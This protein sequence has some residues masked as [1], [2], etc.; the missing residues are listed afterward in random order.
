MKRDVERLR[1]R[2]I[3]MAEKVGA[4]RDA[5]RQIIEDAESLVE[6]IDRAHDLMNEAA[7]ALSEIV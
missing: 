3:K 5:L 1:V 4:D 7:D 6:S 2:L